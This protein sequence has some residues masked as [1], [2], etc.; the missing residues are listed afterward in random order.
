MKNM[1]D[2]RFE[3]MAVIFRL[4]EKE[5]YCHLFT[6]YQRDVAEIFAKF[7][8]HPAVKLIK[9]FDGSNGIWVGWHC[10]LEFAV[11]IEKK[12]EGFV[13]IED[14]SS[15]GNGWTETA[16]RDF[17]P[18]FNDF[19]LDTN[20]GEFF[21]SYILHF[22]EVTRNFVDNFY[23]KID[24]DWFGKY[25]DSSNLRCI[26]S[27]SSG[28]YGAI[29]ND[30]IIYCLVCAGNAI[31]ANAKS[32][33]MPPIIHEYCHSFANP[34]AHRWYKENPEFKKWCV[35]SVNHD[36]MPYYSNGRTMANE[37]VTRAY[38]ILY[39]VQHG[40]DLEEWLS[41]ERD[42]QFA[43]SFKYIEDVYKMIL[44]LEP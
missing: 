33:N 28:N 25:V 38:N 23:S 18:L 30:K 29:V 44:E 40:A 41:K 4:A 43:N 16:A 9:S 27:L 3:C 15:I 7:A 21:N 6:D 17:L 42:W 10:T 5:N 12:D 11:C 32:D 1:V 14:I 2:E 35:D 13:F 24:L 34:L 19:Y 26:Y 8:E 37:Y 39:E 31:S 36:K 22:E 20:Y